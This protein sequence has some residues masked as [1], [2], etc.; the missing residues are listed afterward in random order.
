MDSGTIA[1]IVTVLGVITAY[2]GYNVDPT[3]LNTAVQGV[4]AIVTVVA[5]AWSIY[6]HTQKV[7]V[8]N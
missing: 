1:A 4:V 2:F 7:P 6:K 5:G 3:L 8:T